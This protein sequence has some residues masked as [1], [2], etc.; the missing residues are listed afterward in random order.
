MN[1]YVVQTGDTIDKI[2][3]DFGISVD[4]LII[5]NDLTNPY[6]LVPGEVIIIVHPDR[7]YIVQEGDT[8]ETIA[9]S[10]N[11]SVNELLRNNPII[12]ELDYIYPG[13][14]LN[15]SF[16]RTGKVST[17]GFANTFIDRKTLKKTLPYLTY[18]S[19]FNYR[20]VK[21]GELIGSNDDIDIIELSKQYGVI[22][23]ML[24]TTLSV[25]GEVDIE[26]T[27]DV[28][29]NEDIQNRLFDNVIKAVKDKGYYG[30]NIS[31]QFITTAN[32]AFFEKYVQ[33]LSDMLHQEGL[34]SII[35]IN[36]RVSTFNDQIDFETIQYNTIASS[37]DYVTFM[38]YKWGINDSPPSPVISINNL[39]I[40]FDYILTQ[41]EPENIISG[42][43]TLGYIWELPYMPGFSRGNSLTV[44]S[45]I[46]LARNVGAS[47]EFDEASQTPYFTYNDSNN[48]QYIVWFVNAITVDS[49]IKML[50]S[51]GILGTGVWNIMIYYAHLWLVINCQY[52]IIKLLPEL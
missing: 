9:L 28:L 8:I 16:N 45:A 49:F 30:V 27:Y 29:I 15:I 10:N 5:D 32:Q 19:I 43:S 23:L 31:A 46:N 38:Q 26:L 36:P 33:R 24:M 44:E 1:I 13:Q 3:D 4:K 17:L 18:L 22:P 12:T 47:I 21:N 6:D 2:A 11:I 14:V 7:V 51:K 48:I 20:T 35:T 40:F 52:E 50:L 42:I 41:I 25:Q 39:T 37:V 34:L